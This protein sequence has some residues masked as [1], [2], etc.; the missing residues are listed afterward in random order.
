METER[1]R[2]F[3]REFAIRNR[4]ADTAEVL[5]AITTLQGAMQRQH[6][7][8]RIG[9]MRAGLLEMARAIAVTHV[10]I[11]K[12]QSDSRCPSRLFEATGE[13]D[14]IMRATEMATS[15]ILSAAEKVQEQAWTL[16]ERQH[17]G[18]ECDALE[19]CATEIYAACGFQDLTAQRTRKVIETLRFVEDRIKLMMEVWDLNPVE[20]T[21]AEVTGSPAPIWPDDPAQQASVDAAFTAEHS[22]VA[23]SAPSASPRSL[24]EID[25]LSVHDR[26]T[27]FR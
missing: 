11:G 25:A 17:S 10:E 9:K 23:A 4:Q 18:G 21:A 5:A 1:G 8:Q 16:R 6:D 2:W 22:L 24:A 26:L 27:M 12:I 13:L 15:T 20:P 19:A 7:D 14:A 3:L